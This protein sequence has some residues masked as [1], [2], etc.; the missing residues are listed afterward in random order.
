MKVNSKFTLEKRE[1][2]WWTSRNAIFSKDN[3]PFVSIEKF[4]SGSWFAAVSDG[5]WC[6]NRAFDITGNFWHCLKELK[7]FCLT[8]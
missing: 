5:P 3:E 6:E 1:N 8:Y 4:E 7:K 2:G